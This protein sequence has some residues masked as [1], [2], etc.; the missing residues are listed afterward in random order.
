MSYTSSR[1]SGNGG[2]NEITEEQAQAKINE[3]VDKL[4]KDAEKFL[5]PKNTTNFDEMFPEYDTYQIEHYSLKELKS[6]YVDDFNDNIKRGYGLTYYDTDQVMNILY[7]DGSQ[8]RVDTD[9]DETK[10][11]KTTGIDSI[12]VESGWGSAVA[13]KHIR[14]YDNNADVAIGD[15]RYQFKNAI[16]KYNAIQRE[17]ADLRFDFKKI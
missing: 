6:T 17:G 11:I 9:W 7:K 13:G 10:K 2:S 12:I 8:V 1:K 4:E 3:Y 15:G 5:N 14:M 16:E